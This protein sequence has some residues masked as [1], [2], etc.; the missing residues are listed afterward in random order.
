MLR[1]T[2]ILNYDIPYVCKHDQTEDN[3]IGVGK[4]T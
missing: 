4:F 3:I 1:N 2:V